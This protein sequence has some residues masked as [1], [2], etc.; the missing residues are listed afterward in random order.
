MSEN[1]EELLKIT[2]DNR[3]YICNRNTVYNKNEETAACYSKLLPM[4]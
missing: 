2:N 1:L 4:N 3:D